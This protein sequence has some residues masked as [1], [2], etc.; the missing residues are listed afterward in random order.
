MYQLRAQ[1]IETGSWTLSAQL[2]RRHPHLRIYEMH[3]GGGLYDCLAYVDSTRNSILGMYNRV[4]SFHPFKN[5]A[6]KLDRSWS[7]NELLLQNYELPE[8]VDRMEL[9]MG[10][11]HRTKAKE[12]TG[13][14]LV[15]RAIAAFLCHAS[16][17]RTGWSARSGFLDTSGYGGGEQDQYFDAI[18]GAK[19]KYQERLGEFRRE[20]RSPNETFVH[21][22]YEFWFLIN[23]VGPQAAI[24]IGGHFWVEGADGS[25]T[26]I[27]SSSGRKLNYTMARAFGSVM[28]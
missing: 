17:S 10:L 23:E 4:G 6:P 1:L 14:V 12:T 11:P 15:Y 3:P 25:L 24:H 20:G 19:R 22:A 9:D 18:P 26:K 16:F 5:E 8:L 21:P 7:P 13:Q 27:F 2:A 28:E